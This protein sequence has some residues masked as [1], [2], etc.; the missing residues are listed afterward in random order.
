LKRN[1]KSIATPNLLLQNLRSFRDLR[2]NLMTEMKLYIKVQYDAF[3]TAP[4]K[5]IPRNRLDQELGTDNV[6]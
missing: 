1:S 2:L 3:L 4:N 5:D 6:K